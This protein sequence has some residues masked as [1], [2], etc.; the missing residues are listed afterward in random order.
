MWTAEAIPFGMQRGMPQK[1]LDEGL[2]ALRRS[3]TSGLRIDRLA[4]RLGVTKGSF[5]AHFESKADYVD[6]L[7]S[8]WRGR[9]AP[10][11]VDLFYEAPGPLSNQLLVLSKYVEQS[12]RSRHDAGMRELAKE[13]DGAAEAV[14]IIDDARLEFSFDVFRRAGFREAEAKARGCLLYGWLL[15]SVLVH[16]RLPENVDEV[17]RVLGEGAT[18][19]HHSTSSPAPRVDPRGPAAE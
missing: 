11:D 18:T 12:E 17:C 10:I 19:R 3:G 13:Y 7:C 8:Y 4:E 15:A 6:Q 2:E 9:A 14:A 16:G 1:W 5:Y